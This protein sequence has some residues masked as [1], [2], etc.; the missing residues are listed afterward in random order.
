M[1]AVQETES[2]FSLSDLARVSASEIYLSVFLLFFRSSAK[3]WSAEA[4]AF[5]GVAGVFF[6]QILLIVSLCGWF[7]IAVDRPLVRTIGFVGPIS[8]LLYLINNHFLVSRRMGTKFEEQSRH[9]ERS[10]KVALQAWALFQVALGWAILMVSA[11]EYQ[12]Y[13]PPH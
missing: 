7:S 2:E 8:I 5:K 1:K 9:F 10:K 3:Q 11:Y 13:F 12:R 6:V 4:N